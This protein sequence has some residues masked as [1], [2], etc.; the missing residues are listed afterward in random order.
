M[1]SENNQVHPSLQTM[2]S[3]LGEYGL[4]REEVRG[5]VVE[6]EDSDRVWERT[7]GFTVAKHKAY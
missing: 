6:W 7:A 4:Q 5:E 2:G 3:R 1:Q